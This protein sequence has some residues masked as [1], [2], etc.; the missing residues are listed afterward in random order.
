[1]RRRRVD[2]ESG[3][4]RFGMESAESVA[5]KAALLVLD[6]KSPP[7]STFIGSSSEFP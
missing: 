7:T 1:M 3:T 2:A 6:T 5:E 4:A